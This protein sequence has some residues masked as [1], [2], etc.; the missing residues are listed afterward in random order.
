M[1]ELTESFKYIFLDI[2]KF[3]KRSVEAQ[4]DVIKELNKIVKESVQ[5]NGLQQDNIIFIPTGDGICLAIRGNLT[6]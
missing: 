1:A 2:V 3:T 6:L 4:S 5:T